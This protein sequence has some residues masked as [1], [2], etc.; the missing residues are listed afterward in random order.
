MS[1]LACLIAVIQF[2]ACEDAANTQKTIAGGKAEPAAFTSAAMRPYDVMWQG[3]YA[4]G[5]IGYGSGSSTQSYDRN[6]NH[7]LATVH[8]DGFVL[9]GTAG[10]NF[11]FS[12]RFLVGA[13]ADL[14][15]MSLSSGTHTIYDGH[16]W[17]AKF[18]PLWGT[19]RARVG[20]IMGDWM[21][22]GTG[23]LA[24]M[25]TDSVSIGNTAPETAKDDRFRT[26]W[27]LGAGVEFA[28]ARNMS[29][30]LEYLHLGFGKYSGVSANNEDFYFKD[31]I[32]MVR[33]GVNFHF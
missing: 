31:K 23:G 33:V 30:K 5:S 8:P 6:N 17:N 24:F 18:G 12:E 28:F 25:H 21:F 29:A 4:G 10:Y 13:E 15:F 26:G 3:P 20:Y 7:G 22:F 27:A 2:G 9:S 32:D 19:A 1:S 16:R 14:G 11:L